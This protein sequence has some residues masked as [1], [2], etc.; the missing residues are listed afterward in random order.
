MHLLNVPPAKEMQQNGADLGETTLGI[1][2]NVEEHEL[3]LYN[4]DERI[5]LLEKEN[6]ELREIIFEMKKEW[7]KL[8]K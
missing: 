3:Y 8:K 1:L 7:E 5:E 2:Q 4:H 6:K